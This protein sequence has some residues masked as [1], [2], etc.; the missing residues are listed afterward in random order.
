MFDTINNILFEKRKNVGLDD[1]SS[2]SPYMVSRYLSFYD[3]SMVDYCN[4]TV[5]KYSQVFDDDK[6]LF[7][8]YQNI[9]PKIKRKK[10]SYIK[11]L[12]EDKKVDD[13]HCPDFYSKREIE[14]L[15]NM[16]D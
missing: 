12:K 5:N 2:F 3:D 6:E 9:I 15:T 11:R 8:F 7:D 1:L 16:I 13:I 4:E 14:M 10:I